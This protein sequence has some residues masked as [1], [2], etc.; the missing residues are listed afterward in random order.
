MFPL[1]LSNDAQLGWF[2]EWFFWV[3]EQDLSPIVLVI[4]ALRPIPLDNSVQH[5]AGFDQR[6]ER[7]PLVV[8]CKQSLRH[9]SGP[10][11]V[12]P[13]HTLNSNIPRSNHVHA[14]VGPRPCPF[15]FLFSSCERLVDWFRKSSI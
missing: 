2:F 1:F 6:A 7:Q 3:Y 15:S 12:H 4:P 11:M 5:L 10:T 14:M 13:R 8:A 9:V